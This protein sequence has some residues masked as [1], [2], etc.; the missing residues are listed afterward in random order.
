MLQELFTRIERLEAK[1]NQMIRIGT[2]KTLYPETGRVR[3]TIADAD[4]L[5]SYTL[6]VLY[7]KT[8]ADRHY[9][10]PDAGEHVIC[11]F[12]PIGLEQGFVIGAFYSAADPVPVSDPDKHHIRFKDGTFIE[13]DRKAG[14]ME[15]RCVNEIIVKAARHIQAW[16]P[17]IDLN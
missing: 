14:V 4:G 16:A 17:R 2:V 9:H 13:Y 5:L 11:V 8:H 10:M 7:P 12:L 3:V 15:V 1:L 6:P